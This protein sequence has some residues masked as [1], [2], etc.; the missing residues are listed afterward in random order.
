VDRRAE[1][2]MKAADEADDPLVLTSAARAAT[3]A[4]LA[5]GR[6]EDALNLGATAAK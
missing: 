6:Y 4:L 5:V 1:R 3:H 2:A